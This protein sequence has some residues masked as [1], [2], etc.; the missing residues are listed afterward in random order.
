MREPVK[1]DANSVLTASRC[2]ERR[3]ESVQNT[4][5]VKFKMTVREQVDVYDENERNAF[6]MINSIDKSFYSNR[7]C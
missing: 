6:G 1:I 3:A 5:S 7:M 2:G 4:K